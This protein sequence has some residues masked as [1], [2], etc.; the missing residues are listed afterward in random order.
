MLQTHKLCT[1]A[2]HLSLQYYDHQ[3]LASPTLQPMKNTTDSPFHLKGDE[4]IILI[5]QVNKKRVKGR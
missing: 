5:R 1:A 2:K 3:S 4:Q